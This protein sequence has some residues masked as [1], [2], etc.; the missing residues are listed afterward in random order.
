MLCV[1]T[2][3]TVKDENPE[4][5]GPRKGMNLFWTDCGFELP[6]MS[7]VAMVFV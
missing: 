4:R 3:F 7:L 1:K 2:F 6:T 5:S